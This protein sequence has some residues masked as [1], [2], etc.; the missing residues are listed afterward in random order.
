MGCAITLCHTGSP[1]G[2]EFPDWENTVCL[3]NPAGNFAFNG[4]KQHPLG[5]NSKCPMATQTE[6]AEETHI[7]NQIEDAST[8]KGAGLLSLSIGAIIGIAVAALVGAVIVVVVIVK[9][10]VSANT[11]PS[12]DAYRDMS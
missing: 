8:A 10:R 11:R 7:N 6:I 12:E 9:F 3:Y 1:W 4:V 2:D 5:D